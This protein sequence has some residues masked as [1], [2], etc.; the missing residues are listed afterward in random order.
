[1]YWHPRIHRAC[2][3]RPA[4]V[5]TARKK[6]SRLSRLSVLESWNTAAT[7]ERSGAMSL[8][9]PK[10][11][12]MKCDESAD[13]QQ[14]HTMTRSRR[15]VSI[16]SIPKQS[17]HLLL[18]SERS[19]ASPAG[20][21]PGRCSVT[22]F[23]ESPAAKASRSRHSIAASNHGR[24][25]PPGDDKKKARKKMTRSRRSGGAIVPPLATG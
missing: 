24:S 8:V 23:R 16:L 10:N 4:S 12:S 5:S 15:A 19:G 20:C 9:I 25:D 6:Q 22:G 11:R 13:E 18:S 2:H 21:P 1:M 7:A 14:F 3:L 17:R